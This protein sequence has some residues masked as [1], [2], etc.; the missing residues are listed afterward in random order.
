[1]ADHMAVLHD[2]V[3]RYDDAR[4]VQLG[5]VSFYPDAVEIGVF[6]SKTDPLLDP[7]SGV[8]LCNSVFV[9]VCDSLFLPVYLCRNC[10]C[11]QSGGGLERASGA[12]ALLAV[13]RAGLA[14][15][16]ALLESVFRPVAARL[17]A[18]SSF[19]ADSAEPS[20][21]STWPAEVRDFVIPLY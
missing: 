12:R 17:A 14:R 9:S 20:A 5:D 15:L 8:S 4:E 18:S 6:G 2:C 10:L 21:M 11:L 7:P 1:M 13:T 3:L 19:P 16:A